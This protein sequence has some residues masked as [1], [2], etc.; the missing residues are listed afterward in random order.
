MSFKKGDVPECAGAARLENG[1]VNAERS[2]TLRIRRI[3]TR[4]TEKEPLGA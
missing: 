1:A 3:S 4:T 2:I